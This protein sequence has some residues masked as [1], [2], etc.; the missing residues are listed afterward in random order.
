MKFINY[1]TE[2]LSISSRPFE[3]EEELDTV[4]QITFNI[5]KKGSKRKFEIEWEFRFY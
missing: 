4:A 1:G 3:I 2:Y 5:I